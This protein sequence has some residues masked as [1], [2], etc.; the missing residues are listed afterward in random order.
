MNSRKNWRG[1]MSDLDR[2]IAG[3]GTDTGMVLEPVMDMNFEMDMGMD[4]G[5]DAIGMDAM[6]THAMRMVPMGL[7]KASKDE[8]AG[9]EEERD[10]VDILLEQWTTTTTMTTTMT[11]PA[12]DVGMGMDTLRT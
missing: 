12:P 4:L 11:P 7:G 2:A 5:M 6:G 3:V 8:Y 1:G 9:K 10:I